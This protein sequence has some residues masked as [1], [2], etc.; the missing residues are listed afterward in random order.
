MNNINWT[1]TSANSKTGNV[2][3]AYMGNTIDE[4]KGTCE[5]VACPLFESKVH[6]NACYAHGGTVKMGFWA[7]IKTRRRLKEEVKNLLSLASLTRRQKMKVSTGKRRYTLD[8]AINN[9]WRGAKIVRFTALGDGGLV[10]SETCESIKSK[11]TKAGMKICG[12]TRGWRLDK[13]QQWKG[14]LMASCM[15]VEEVDEAM[16]KGWRASVVL[17]QDFVGK[18]FT[19][20]KGRKGIVCPHF[21][22]PTITCNTCQLCVGKNRGPVIGFPSHR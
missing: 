1:P 5:A 16:D 21:N 9:S 17:P 13:A 7:I 20:P 18:R 3:Q 11:V 2:P 10:D 14:W 15:S 4:C 19:T 12:Y 22:E 6:G 8:Y